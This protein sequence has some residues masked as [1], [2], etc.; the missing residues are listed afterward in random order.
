MISGAAVQ[1][2]IWFTEHFCL[3]CI[4]LYCDHSLGPDEFCGHSIKPSTFFSWSKYFLYAMICL[5][6]VSNN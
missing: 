4:L 6:I 3:L 2:I 5:F 1:T